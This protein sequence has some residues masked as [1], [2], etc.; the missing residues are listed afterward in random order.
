[1]ADKISELEVDA[2]FVVALP[3]LDN[4]RGDFNEEIPKGGYRVF[5]DRAG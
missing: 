4:G 5:F 1:M 3:L 2:D